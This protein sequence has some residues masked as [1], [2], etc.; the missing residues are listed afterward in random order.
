MSKVK[1]IYEQK[2][3]NISKTPQIE[4]QIVTSGGVIIYRFG[5]LGM[6][7]L[8]VNSRGGY[9]DF[10]GKIDGSDQSI[11]KTVARETYEESNKLLNKKQIEARLVTAPYIYIKNSK[12]VCFIIEATHAESLLQ[13]EDFGDI[14]IHDNIERTVKWIPL[15]MILTPE[16]IKHKLNWRLK[17]SALFAKLNEINN[18]KKLSVSMF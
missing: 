9:E 2:T 18:Q 16:I 4:K 5:D 13:S 1:T 17:S 14:E 11:Y 12:Y 3:F 10:G 15:S 7:L 6:E 8:L